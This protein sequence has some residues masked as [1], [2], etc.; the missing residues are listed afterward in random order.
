MACSR[1]NSGSDTQLMGPS[2]GLQRTGVKPTTRLLL[3]LRVSL[4]GAVPQLRHI[5]AL[6][7]AQLSTK[8]TLVIER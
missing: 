5:S 3:G 7:C 6:R 2:A 8:V 1:A 4:R